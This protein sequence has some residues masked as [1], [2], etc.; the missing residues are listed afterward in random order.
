MKGMER[1]EDREIL[2]TAGFPETERERLSRFRSA[3]KD[4]IRQPSAEDR[5]IEFVRWLVATGKL[6]D[7]IA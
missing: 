6:T 1:R 3:S 7:Q 2:R 5:R 4:R